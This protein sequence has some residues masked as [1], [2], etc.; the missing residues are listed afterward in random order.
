[1]KTV[2]QILAEARK[3]K[4]LTL[5]QVE[6]ATKIRKKVLQSLEDGDWSIL[7]SAT[8]VKGLLRNYGSFLELN[9]N[10]LL[11][12]YRREFDERK[13]KQEHKPALVG[14]RR[15]RLTPKWVTIAVVLVAVVGVAAYLFVQYRNFTGTPLLEVSQ[16]EDNIKIESNQVSVVGR[17]WPDAV[18][19]ING[20]EV[21]LSAGGSFSVAVSLPEGVNTITVTAANRFGRIATQKRTLVV[22]LPQSVSPA[23]VASG[24]NLELSIGPASVALTVEVDGKVAFEGVL[25]NGAKKSFTAKK[26]IRL[27]THNAGSTKAFFKGTEAILGKEGE[28]IEKVFQ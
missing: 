27:L 24:V 11:A 9:P 23:P 3:N 1:M 4:G 13:S 12:F 19:K 5:E 7:P 16:P 28:T 8:F 18:L 6:T 10:D 22:D 2:G 21:Q 14:T 26:R 15:F 17:T 20:Q 25:A